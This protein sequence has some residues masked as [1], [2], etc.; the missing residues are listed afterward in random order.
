MLAR[1]MSVG[2]VPN[3]SLRQLET[4]TSSDWPQPNPDPPD[5]VGF[6]KASSDWPQPDPDPDPTSVDLHEHDDLVV[7]NLGF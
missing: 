4:R 1:T 3:V 5:A 2:P 6:T 7:G